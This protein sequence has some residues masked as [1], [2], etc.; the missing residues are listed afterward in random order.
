[1]ATVARSAAGIAQQLSTR[2][3]S[4]ASSLLIAVRPPGDILAGASSRDR[5]GWAARRRIRQHTCIDRVS[6]VVPR[7]RKSR[8]DRVTV[9]GDQQ[10]SR[11]E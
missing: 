7:G 8:H 11:V 4:S 5:A 3:E 9:W 1:M 10:S 6:C 2:G